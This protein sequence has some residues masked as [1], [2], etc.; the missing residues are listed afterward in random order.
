MPKV[1]GESALADWAT[2]VAGLNVRPTPSAPPTA[3]PIPSPPRARFPVTWQALMSSVP[4]LAM[5]P[6]MPQ[7][8]RPNGL[9]LASPTAAL[10]DTTSLDRVKLPKLRTP[11]PMLAGGGEFLL[12]RP[13]V[14][15][16]PARVTGPPLMTKP[17][18]RG[19]A[20][21]QLV[22]PWALD[23]QA[24]GDLQ[25]VTGQGDGPLDAEGDR[26]AR[27]VGVGDCLAQGAGAAVV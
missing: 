17:G 18:G 10:S 7:P 11:P 24:L 26:V 21:R 20:D 3:T 8:V 5:P 15:V 14:I 22:G 13:P 25:R 2:P 6:P 12:A 16:I 19:A 1:W 27:G 4:K 23:V 9:A